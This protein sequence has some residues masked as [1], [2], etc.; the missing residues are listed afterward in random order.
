ML[1]PE[2]VI[3][4]AVTAEEKTFPQIVLEAP[5]VVFELAYYRDMLDKS[6][7]AMDACIHYAQQAAR[8]YPTR[9]AYAKAEVSHYRDQFIRLS[10]QAAQYKQRITEMET[11]H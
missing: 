8:Y 6:L 1:Q 9:P 4:P 3:I 7:I 2:T 5:P 10:V 11:A